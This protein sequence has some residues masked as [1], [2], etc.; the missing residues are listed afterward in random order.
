MTTGVHAARFFPSIWSASLRSMKQSN[1]V[2]QV[3]AISD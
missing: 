3:L 1:D 2:D